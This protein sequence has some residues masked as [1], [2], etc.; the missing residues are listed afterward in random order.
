MI[1][2]GDREGCGNPVQITGRAGASRAK[3]SSSS[4]VVAGK[5]VGFWVVVIELDRLKRRDGIRGLRFV[6]GRGP[7]CLGGGSASTIEEPSFLA[8][9]EDGP[10]TFD[11]T[12]RLTSSWYSSGSSL[13]TSIRMAF[14]C[15]LG[16][17]VMTFNMSVWCMQLYVQDPRF[18]WI[19]LYEA[20]IRGSSPALNKVSQ[21]SLSRG[22]YSSG[23]IK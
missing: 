21:F 22:Y 18:L 9:K 11:L 13:G 6:V 14:R 20:Y 19:T 5:G 8:G 16:G 23:L 10:F 15:F 12:F 3:K 1:E 7:D 17:S 2:W 4:G